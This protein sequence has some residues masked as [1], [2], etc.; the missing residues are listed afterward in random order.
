MPDSNQ[1]SPDLYNVLHESTIPPASPVGPCCEEP[2][3]ATSS[4]TS[5]SPSSDTIALSPSPS[6]S[7]SDASLH[8]VSS[9]FEGDIEHVDPF[10]FGCPTPSFRLT[11]QEPV[12]VEKQAEVTEPQRVAHRPAIHI[13]TRSLGVPITGNFWPSMQTPP[14]QTPLP[15]IPTSAPAIVSPPAALPL[16]PATLGS[17]A[18]SSLDS[19]LSSPDSLGDIAEETS[20]SLSSAFSS[21]F[22]NFDS[23]SQRSFR[24]RSN[25]DAGSTEADEPGIP[26]DHNIYTTSSFSCSSLLEQTSVGKGGVP[27]RLRKLSRLSIRRKKDSPSLDI[28]VSRMPSFRRNVSE[29]SNTTVDS[30]CEE[31]RTPVDAATPFSP[32]VHKHR[33]GHSWSRIKERIRTQVFE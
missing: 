3:N 16:A 14:P 13:R 31:L 2:G 25:S 27:R 10:M 20:S 1:D 22:L 8:T 15:P 7:S 18:R 23:S 17:L 5:G 29:D 4:S 26:L 30:P 21:S 24:S 19:A 32:T 11:P 12:F 28:K 33:R 9:H 6:V